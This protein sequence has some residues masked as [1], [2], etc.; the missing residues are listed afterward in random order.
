MEDTRKFL[1]NANV[2]AAL[3]DG[4][5]KIIKERPEQPLAR[6]AEILT[7]DS[8]LK[9]SPMVA[10][11]VPTG[12]VWVVT[13]ANQGNGLGLC[14]LLLAKQQVVYALCRKKSAGLAA[15]D[16]KNVTI[17]EG[18][19]LAGD[20]AFVKDKIKGNV[21][22]IVNNAGVFDITGSILDTAFGGNTQ[23][24]DAVS[25]E[26]MRHCFEVNALGPLKLVQLLVGQ[27]K[28][29]GKIAN[30]STTAASMR[31]NR[32]GVPLPPPGGWLAYRSSKAALN[33]ITRSMAV[34]LAPKGISVIAIHPGILETSL[35]I[36][37]N[38]VPDMAKPVTYTKEQGAAGTL[39]SILW[40]SLQNSGAYVDGL[41]FGARK[42][43]DGTGAY[44]LPF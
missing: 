32:P 2:E 27:M 29:G 3:A 16:G 44:I 9:V 37:N 25:M 12:Q 24:L 41:N 17:I 13:G 22:F 38:P 42:N 4:V 36:G 10:Q 20:V 31:V 6:L 18:V 11:E 30:I 7:E 35:F 23:T 14:E 34:D 43:N 33:M 26:N 5:A 8:M 19:D 1:E 39:S 21:D 40:C 28:P 15:L